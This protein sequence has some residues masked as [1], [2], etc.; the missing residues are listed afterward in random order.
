MSST[1][2]GFVVLIF[3]I[4]RNN[5]SWETEMKLR[6]REEERGE[7]EGPWRDEGRGGGGKR[8]KEIDTI[9][10]WVEEVIFISKIPRW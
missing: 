8:A 6:L 1:K 7:E 4:K 9:E 10:T 5:K 3:C 2:F